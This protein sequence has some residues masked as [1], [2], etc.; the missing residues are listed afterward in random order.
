MAFTP[1]WAGR[2]KVG[3]WMVCGRG[4]LGAGGE[5]GL[6]LSAIQSLVKIPR[7]R[8][9]GSEQPRNRTSSSPGKRELRSGMYGAVG[10][11]FFF[12]FLFYYFFSP[13]PRAPDGS[14]RESVWAVGRRWRTHAPSPLGHGPSQGPGGRHRRES[15][16]RRVRGFARGSF[17]GTEVCPGEG[18][19][20]GYTCLKARHPSVS[21]VKV[22]LCSGHLDQPDRR[23]SP[24]A[25]GRKR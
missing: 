25:D 12:K 15:G 1:G 18:F 17:G 24:D 8:R 5:D 4:R 21:P 7:R 3:D 16:A 10:F 9:A 2:Q 6:S 13:P 23:L 14:R 11:Y 20:L 22:L 19:C